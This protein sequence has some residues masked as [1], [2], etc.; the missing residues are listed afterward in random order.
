LNFFTKRKRALITAAVILCVAMMAFSAAY[1]TNP[2]FAEGVLA[3]I[4]IPAQKYITYA[5]KWVGDQIN[6]LVSLKELG[7]EN[8]RL[9]DELLFLEAE[10]ARLRNAEE[11]NAELRELLTINRMYPE[12]ETIGAVI[13]AKD[14]GNWYANFII[15]KGARDDL[16]NNMAVLAPGGLVGRIIETGANYAKVKTLIDDTS[17]VSA[18]SSRTGEIGVVKGDM[19][20]MSEGLCRMEHI[21]IDA[22]IIAGDEIVTSYL[23]E[24]YPPGIVIGVV[25]E[26][27]A[28]AG[29]LTKYAIVRPEVDFKN[30]ETVLIINRLFGRELVDDDDAEDT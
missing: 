29:G 16:K 10:A 17:A 3:L 8:A 12:Y 22:E 14:P 25:T 18:R 2:T 7:E 24:I 1:R 6:F 13:I 27:N 21:D 11:E 15:D 9:K 4:I 30:L 28:D 20:L 23:G 5:G 19:R 26:V